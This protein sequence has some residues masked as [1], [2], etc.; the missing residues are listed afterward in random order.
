ME[1]FCRM[2]FHRL[3]AL[4]AVSGIQLRADWQAEP[5]FMF[6]MS[7]APTRSRAGFSHHDPNPRRVKMWFKAIA[8]AV[9]AA[10]IAVFSMAALAQ[11]APP[12]YGMNISVDAA[13][14]ASAAAVAEARKNNWAMAIAVT[15]TA[16]NLVYF[17]RMDDTQVGSISVAIGKSRSAALFKRPTKV[18]Q[19]LVAKGA[20]FTYL[21]GLEG[22]VVVQGGI[23]IVTDGKLVGA[24]GCSGG[25]GAQDVQTCTAGL[26]AL[27]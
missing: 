22:A 4:G 14:K 16:G 15:D 11:Q 6:T 10:S 8:R 3:L 2:R 23:P 21:L 19:D 13:K 12:P 26:A 1:A 18:F 25:S 9:L 20:D 5:L 7:R 17:E 27:Q 24:I